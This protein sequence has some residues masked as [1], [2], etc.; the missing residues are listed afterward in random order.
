MRTTTQMAVLHTTDPVR[1]PFPSGGAA[2]VIGACLERI[3]A[4]D[5]I[6]N[7]MVHVDGQAALA[8]AAECDEL[9]AHGQQRGLL[10]GMPV[11]VKDNIDTAGA[12]TTSGSPAVTRT[13]DRDAPAI[14][15]L[16]Q[17]GAIILGK[18][19]LDE[20][21]LGATGVNAHLGRCRNPWD[22]KRVPG[23]SS[24][25]PAAA[26]AAGMSI[27]GVGTDT[28]GSVRT[29]A[30]LTGLV[31]LRP[32]RG[33]IPLGG[34]TP[35]SP[36]L[37]TVGPMARTA[38]DVLRMF[39]AMAGHTERPGA[40][41]VDVA[42]AMHGL[43]G[44]RVGIPRG[45]FAQEC[46]PQ[47]A[48]RVAIAAGVLRDLG[49]VLVDISLPDPA[50]AHAQLSRLML[51]DAYRFH[52]DRLAKEPDTYGRDVRTRILAG[53]EVSGA[54]YSDARA[55]A[56]S[57]S[58]AVRAAFTDVEVMMSPTTPQPAP[59][60]TDFTDSLTATARLTRFTYPWTLAAVPV[61]SI[62][63]GFVD[64]LPVGMQVVADHHRED[65]LFRVAIDYQRATTWHREWPADVLRP[66]PS[67][68][69]PDSR[70]DNQR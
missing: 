7:A 12:P 19:N 62:P 28:S 67:D 66:L 11:V 60:P 51:A 30:A 6:L 70:K 48:E 46:D 21:A 4:L 43:R 27:G 65:L 47:V 41:A 16:R 38:V 42:S 35:V 45:Y 15:R 2:A 1:A 14:G 13:P 3:E 23:G 57:W 32:S 54:E 20:F 25:G 37:D 69:S 29:P 50:P 24:G 64:G 31:G 22:P 5:L 63:C 58:R 34:I 52:R 26:V 61:I 55:W 53:R 9:S 59:R 49:A 17:A 39:L 10:H 18:A 44:L 36:F 56:D 8:T 40:G 33:R 68:A